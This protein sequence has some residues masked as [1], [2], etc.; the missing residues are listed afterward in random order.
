MLP[1]PL[2]V[3]HVRVQV[4]S[5][6]RIE[7]HGFDFGGARFNG[8]APP[9]GSVLELPGPREVLRIALAE[10]DFDRKGQPQGPVPAHDH[11][12]VN[13]R[14]GL[15]GSLL[16]HLFPPFGTLVRGRIRFRS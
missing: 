12:V 13:G 10:A 1:E 4:V 9:H 3:A 5:P 11:V 7:H 16:D 6:L 2:V 15:L 14:R 8:Q